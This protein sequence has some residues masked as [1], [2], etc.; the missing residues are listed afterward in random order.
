MDLWLESGDLNDTNNTGSKSIEA[1]CMIAHEFHN[2]MSIK[3]ENI[4]PQFKKLKIHV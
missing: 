4:L 1:Q 3:N 2:T